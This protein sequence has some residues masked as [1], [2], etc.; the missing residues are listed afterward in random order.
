MRWTLALV[1]V[2]LGV[3]TP[4]AMA[5]GLHADDLSTQQTLPAPPGV[6]AVAATT[7]GRMLTRGPR[8]VAVVMVNFT[9]LPAT[10]WTADEARTTVFTGATSLNAFEHEQSFGAV[11]LAGKLRADGDVFGWYTIP[12]S[13][14]TC[15][16]DAWMAGAN[17]AAVA[18]GVDLTG[19]QHHIY[20][21][22]RVAACGWSGAADMPGTDSFING[23]MSTR[24]LAHEFGHNLGAEHASAL[25]CAD[26]A[27]V[28]VAY[29]TA[30]TLSEYGDPYD[31]MGL[32][33][34]HYAAFRKAEAGFIPAT[35]L[36]TVAQTGTYRIGSSSTQPG[37]GSL[38]VQR[39]TGPDF[40]YFDL[41]SPSGSFENVAASDPSVTG[42]TVRLAG[43]YRTGAR[44]RLIDANPSTAT[45]T[46]AP[47]KPAQG[48]VDPVTGIEIT[49]TA[50]ELGAASVRITVPGT[51]PLP[52][53]EQA[54]SATPAPATSIAL[55]VTA[56]AS[57]RRV[58]ARKGVL[59]VSLPVS[60]GSHSC[61]VKVS[62]RWTPCSISGTS[63]SLTRSLALRTQTVPVQ[64]RLDGNMVL[65][66]RLRV[67]R[68]G[69]TTRFAKS[70]AI[71]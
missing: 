47:F 14:A 33:D 62:G 43:D 50:V 21:F 52:S 65:S 54:R 8:T 60:A 36:T 48:F 39:G 12:Q 58:S 41:R 32:S 27:G 18:A 22:P 17:T 57:L 69:Q 49:V 71:G 19:Y 15:D 16:P 26:A 5:S 28:P 45:F 44:T 61:A 11:S 55:P 9:S 34:R 3:L 25:R 37:S 51:V 63:A 24:V 59:Q 46:D 42:V 6:A 38:R 1:A 64:V 10:P 29:S 56:K 68:T 23:T 53:L 67:P 31:V 2:L 35:G 40:W 30:C 7:T 20:V 13:T 66:V 4:G 70:L